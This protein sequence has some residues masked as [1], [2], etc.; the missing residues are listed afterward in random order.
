MEASEWF[1]CK[2]VIK[3][4]KIMVLV[5]QN[6]FSMEGYHRFGEE[7]HMICQKRMTRLMCSIFN[8]DRAGIRHDYHLSKVSIINGYRMKNTYLKQRNERGRSGETRE[9][10]TKLR[11]HLIP[12]HRRVIDGCMPETMAR[13]AESSPLN[14]G[15][16]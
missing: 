12:I 2:S 5:T 8:H 7:N 6:F 1:G 13:C 9:H 11:V 14:D 15:T 10:S 3:S 16:R 4:K